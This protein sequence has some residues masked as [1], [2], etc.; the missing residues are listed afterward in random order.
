[1][2]RC[3]NTRPTSTVQQ[4]ARVEKDHGKAWGSHSPDHSRGHFNLAPSCVDTTRLGGCWGHSPAMDC[5]TFLLA[6]SYTQPKSCCQV[7]LAQG[8]LLA[9]PQFS[10]YFFPDLFFLCHRSSLVPQESRVLKLKS[11]KETLL[12]PASYFL[13]LCPFPEGVRTEQADTLGKQ[14]EMGRKTRR[15]WL[16]YSCRSYTY[17][18]GKY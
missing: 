16:R 5:L 9:L 18:I 8:G 4:P 13:S 7:G 14:A 11:Q 6:L 15:K 12:P 17:Q 3:G 1:M 10:M 2:E